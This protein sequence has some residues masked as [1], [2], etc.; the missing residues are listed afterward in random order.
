MLIVAVSSLLIAISGKRQ[1]YWISALGIYVFSF[2]AG[3]SIGQLTVGL[4]LIPLALAIG[5][6]SGSIKTKVDYLLA[7]GVGFLLGVIVVIFVHFLTLNLIKK[8]ILSLERADVYLA[9]TL[10]RKRHCLVS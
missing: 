9:P 7:A 8:D 2:I 10:L 4:T 5:C 1:F 3:F 6:S